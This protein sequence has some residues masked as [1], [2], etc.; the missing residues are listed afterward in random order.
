[1]YMAKD[2][3][4]LAVNITARRLSVLIQ[5]RARSGPIEYILSYVLA[6]VWLVVSPHTCPPVRVLTVNW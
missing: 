6:G 1:M 4:Q 3:G 2:A 5:K